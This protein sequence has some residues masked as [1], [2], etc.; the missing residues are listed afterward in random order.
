[1]VSRYGLKPV[2]GILLFGPPGCGKTLF[3]RS[4]AEEVGAKFMH[5]KTSN[6]L[7]PWYG[8]S[9]RNVTKAFEEARKSAPCIIFFDEIEAIARSR[10]KVVSD[11]ITPRIFSLMLAEM[12]GIDKKEGVIVVGATNVPHHLDKALLRPGRLDKLIYIPPPD[13]KARKEIFRIHSEKLPLAEDVDFERLA[14]MTD[15]Y[16]GADIANIC[17]EVARKAIREVISDGAEGEKERN[18]WGL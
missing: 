9:E 4:I 17:Q 8:E 14:K 1:M 18:P 16:S 13:K 3:M 15:R 11:D 5:I 2:S 12:D 10:D 7:S 6:L